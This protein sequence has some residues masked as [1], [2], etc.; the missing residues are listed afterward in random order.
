MEAV[1]SSAMLV[2]NHHI[3]RLNNPENQEIYV[4]NYLFDLR[5]M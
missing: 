4:V 5:D 1:E 2:S 3:A